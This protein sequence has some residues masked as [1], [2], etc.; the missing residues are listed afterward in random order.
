MAML[1]GGNALA[2]HLATNPGILTGQQRLDS[3]ATQLPRRHD[4]TEAGTDHRCLYLQL[5]HAV[6]SFSRMCEPT[7]N[8]VCSP[9]SNERCQGK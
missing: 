8:F 5:L 6:P 4:P 3:R 1:V 7:V 9:I 2:R